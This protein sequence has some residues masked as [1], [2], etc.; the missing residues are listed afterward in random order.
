MELGMCILFAF[1]LLFGLCVL[2]F[3]IC[4]L[5]YYIKRWLKK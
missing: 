2:Y 4:L 3:G 1:G 5:E